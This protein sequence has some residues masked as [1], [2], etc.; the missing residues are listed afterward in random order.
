MAYHTSKT[1]R[2]AKICPQGR[3]D[4]GMHRFS[5]NVYFHVNKA[6]PFLPGQYKRFFVGQNQ[7]GR[8]VVGGRAAW[9]FDF[10]ICCS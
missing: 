5:K 9:F 1:P 7:A 3:W 10:E 4:P 8:K 6:C 2:M